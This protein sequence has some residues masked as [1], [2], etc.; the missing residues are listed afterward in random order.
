MDNSLTGPVRRGELFRL[1]LALLLPTVLIAWMPL[2][3]AVALAVSV[4]TLL[5]FY[6]KRP[7]QLSPFLLRWIFVGCV[8]ALLMFFTK[9]KVIDFRNSFRPW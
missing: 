8:V 3:L 6:V 9:S 4:A 7:S 1:A 5:D 2:V